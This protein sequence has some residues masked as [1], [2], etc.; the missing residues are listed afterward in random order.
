MNSFIRSSTV[1]P[2]ARD[3][4]FQFPHVASRRSGRL[5]RSRGRRA[6]DHN[7]FVSG[8]VIRT[9]NGLIYVIDGVLLPQCR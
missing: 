8:Q 7:A 3:F 1:V 5:R 9:D 4:R 6:A 2:G